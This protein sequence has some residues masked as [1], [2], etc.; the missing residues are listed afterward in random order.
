WGPNHTP[1]PVLELVD[2]LHQAE[3]A[4]LNQVEELQAAVG[5]SLGDRDDEPQ[6]RLDHLLLGLARLA[7][8]LL[9]R[10]DDLAEILD[11]EPGLAGERVDVGADLLDA[12]LVPGDQILPAHGS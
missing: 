5:V 1:A 12:I 8:A 10:L 6:V 9:H 3:V 2:R 7:L 4:F 11:L